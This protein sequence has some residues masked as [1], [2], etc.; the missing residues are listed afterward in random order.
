MKSL[1]ALI[2]VLMVTACSPSRSPDTQTAGALPRTQSAPLV[3]SVAP[4]F[5]LSGPDGQSVALSEFR[6][7]P[8]VLVFWTAWCPLCKEEI[9]KLND[10]HRSGVPV[11]GVNL[12]ESAKR[13]RSAVEKEPIR[14]R[15][16]LD[17]DGSV[18]RTYHVKGTPTVLILDANGIIKYYGN[19]VPSNLEK[20]L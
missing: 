15:V 18:G 3:G 16:V 14:Y 4:E 2:V 7:N 20:L 6:G 11:L 19:D 10:I 9:P 17:F 1:V 12:M 13:V 8:L 5:R